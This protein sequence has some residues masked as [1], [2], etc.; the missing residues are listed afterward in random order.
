MSPPPVNPARPYGYG[1]SPSRLEREARLVLVEELMF[2]RLQSSQVIERALAKEFGVNS[3]TIR[4]YMKRVR[5]RAAIAAQI[6][7]GRL[8][9]EKLTESIVATLNLALDRVK[10][11]E[12]RS[13]PDPDLR[14]ALRCQQA[15][16]SLHGLVVQRHELTGANGEPLTISPEAAA[17]EMRKIVEDVANRRKA[18]APPPTTPAPTPDDADD[19][20][21]EDEP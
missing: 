17:A 16:A 1:S 15:L 9:R 2:R 12:G 14:T 10:W 13:V 8:T 3:R 6:D 21:E 5:E 7:P 20:S 19:G 18:E 11:I 4:T